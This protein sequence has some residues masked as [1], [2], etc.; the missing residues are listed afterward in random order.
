M[1]APQ[2]SIEDI[3]TATRD[4]LGAERV[5]LLT[6]R[7]DV[8]GAAVEVIASFGEPAPKSLAPAL[9]AEL[10][11]RA[12][13]GVGRAGLKRL[14]VALGI[15]SG[16]FSAGF[17]SNG[18]RRELLLATWH[19]GAGLDMTSMNAI[20]ESVI[21]CRAATSAIRSA[22]AKL[23]RERQTLAEHLHDD[24]VQTLTGVVLELDSLRASMAEDRQGLVDTLDVYREEM[25]RVTADAR[26]IV[27][28]LSDGEPGL[29]EEESAAEPENLD[30]F[31]ASMVKRWGLQARVAIEGDIDRVPESLVS[32]AY[33]VIG[34]ALT[35]AAKHASSDD[36]TVKLAATE[37]DLTV[38]ITDRGRGFTPDER[39]AAA[40]A[41]HVGLAM[42]QRRV[43]QMGG[44]LYIESKPG[45]GTRVVA[46][47]PI[48]EV[49]S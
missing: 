34:E 36:V 2:A 10:I 33:A 25:R 22:S 18:D 24:L 32:L 38:S 14:A 5:F 42:L 16:A 37:A 44:K 19:G 7:P 35:N 1:A 3:L 46:R 8:C 21:M 29:E 4:A 39:E 9:L 45:H 49:A 26:A 17:A 28:R 15:R 13:R 43:R 11:E 23:T 40:E 41:H 31:V 27:A 20:A 12:E 6:A 47:L 30:S 48:D